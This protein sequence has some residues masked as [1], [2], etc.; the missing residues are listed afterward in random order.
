[1]IF[2]LQLYIVCDNSACC[3]TLDM[4]ITASVH[5]HL[6]RGVHVAQPGSRIEGLGCRL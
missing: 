1:M 4:C 6:L 2:A 3:V 5:S